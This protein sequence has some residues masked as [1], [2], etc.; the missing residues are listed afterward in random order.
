[1]KNIAVELNIS[2]GSPLF[3]EN[4]RRPEETLKL[5]FEVIT[6]FDEEDKQIAQGVLKCLILKHQAKQSLQRQQAAKGQ[7]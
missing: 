6:Q 4:E 7:I 5:Q 1:L 2:T 3:N